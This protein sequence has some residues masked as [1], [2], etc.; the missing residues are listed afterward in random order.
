MF[1]KRAA[2][3]NS[4]ALQQLQTDKREVLDELKEERKSRDE[5]RHQRFDLETDVRKLTSTRDRLESKIR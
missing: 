3:L 4:E 2:S 1:L 5:L